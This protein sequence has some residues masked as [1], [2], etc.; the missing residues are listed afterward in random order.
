MILHRSSSGAEIMSSVFEVQINRVTLRLTN[1]LS[2]R[3]NSSQH[4]QKESLR[5]CNQYW[6]LICSPVIITMRQLKLGGILC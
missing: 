1:K 6:N 3:A 5:E 4:A 2:W